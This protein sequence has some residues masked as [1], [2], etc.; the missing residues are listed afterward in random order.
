VRPPVIGS[1]TPPLE[2]ATRAPWRS[3]SSGI[4]TWCSPSA[5]GCWGAL[6]WPRTQEA[7]LQALLNLDRL[8]HPDRFGAWLA[9]IGLN[10]C[11]RWL[12]EQAQGAWSW[13]A[14]Q[15]GRWGTEPVDPGPTPESLAEVA[16]GSERVRRAVADLPGGQRDA[17][18]LF[19][20]AG[21]TQQEVADALGT[22]VG[23]VKAR[24][25]KARRSLRVRLSS[26]WKEEDMGVQAGT[27]WLDVR[28]AD[29]R[30]SPAEGGKGERYVV[31]LQE[32][33]RQERGL[34]I[35]VGPFEGTAIAMIL[36]KAELPRPAT[37]SF[38]ASILRAVGGHVREVRITRLADIT[39][40]AEAILE[41]AGGE[42][43][44]DARPSDA[45][46]LALLSD[47]PVRVS[48]AVWESVEEETTG[49]W[50]EFQHVRDRYGSGARDI[51][52]ERKSEW[53]RDMEEFRRR[54]R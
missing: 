13:G 14:L 4:T 26:A 16:E 2:T 42:A 29:V 47:A 36:E 51:S 18:M 25:H 28:V 33:G 20:I 39:Y 48:S 9:G 15:G 1:S 41:G 12:R 52:E 10:L 50:K 54:D 27:E 34:P 46:A 40:Y 24:L 23:A 19:Y 30:R 37:H 8:R 49:S 7:S 22:T 17:V 11:R 44:V 32:E 3:C 35:W 45:L 38:A 31:L 6:I 43:T 53:E 5:T 21:L